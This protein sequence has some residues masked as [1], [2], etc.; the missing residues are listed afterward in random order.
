M[1]YF[2]KIIYMQIYHKAIITNSCNSI[3]RAWQI[4]R[5]FYNHA[6]KNACTVECLIYTCSYGICHT[7]QEVLQQTGIHEHG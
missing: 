5:E 6:C 2:A 1:K 3:L 7:N 4:Q